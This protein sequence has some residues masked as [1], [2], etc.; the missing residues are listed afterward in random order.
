[1]GPLLPH[2]AL[3]EGEFLPVAG[4]LATNHYYTGSPFRMPYQLARAGRLL[5][6]GE[7]KAWFP[8]YGDYDHTV[9]RAIKNMAHQVA[10]GTVSIFGWPLLSLLPMAFSLAELRRDRRVI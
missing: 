10:V 3:E 5:G 7:D 2:G 4:L 8:V 1:M 9:W 6:F